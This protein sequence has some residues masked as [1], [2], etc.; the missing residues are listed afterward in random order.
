[1]QDAGTL[2][3]DITKGDVVIL[4]TSDVHA[5]F[6]DKTAKADKIVYVSG[7]SLKGRRCL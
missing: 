5:A 3:K 1:V 6:E 7:Y 4:D 2:S